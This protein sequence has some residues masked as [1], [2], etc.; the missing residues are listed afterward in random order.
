MHSRVSVVHRL[1]LSMRRQYVRR[2]H[3][4]LHRLPAVQMFDQTP[5]KDQFR[6]RQNWARRIAAIQTPFRSWDQVISSKHP[7]GIRT[8]Q[9]LFMLEAT[10]EE[11]LSPTTLPPTPFALTLPPFPPLPRLMIRDFRPA[12]PTVR[13]FLRRRRS[14]RQSR[15]PPSPPMPQFRPN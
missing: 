14:G 10:M 1:R 9:S 2:P 6:R 7:Q 8:R 3:F 15:H 11:L 13:T 5:I 4:A 12:F